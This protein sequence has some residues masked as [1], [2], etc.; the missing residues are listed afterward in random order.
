MAENAYDAVHTVPT[1]LEA[2]RVHEVGSGPPAVLW[3]SLF[4]D[5]TTWVR[6]RDDLARDRRLF[7]IDGPCHGAG[8]P[9][10]QLF[11]LRDCADAAG[12]V[13]DRL[14]VSE[15]VDWLGNAWGGHVGI[16]FAAS[17]PERC[18]SLVTIGTPVHALSA[19]DRRRT[20]PVVV[21]YRLLGPVRPLSKGLAGALLGRGADPMDVRLVTDAFRRPDRRG[22]YTAMRSVMLRR[23]DLTPTLT[24]VAAPSLFVAG[25]EDALWLPTQARAAAERLPYGASVTVPGA[26]HIAPLLQ[27]AP[28]VAGI[29]TD[30]WRDP[31]GAVV[32]RA[33]PASASKPLTAT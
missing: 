24:D 9:T 21:L 22:M 26:G 8:E 12:E 17:Q 1:R 7:L 19:A 25:A 6:V 10:R 13:L 18:R 33:A 14:E 5:S 11:T 15:P 28:T 2:L 20:V 29:V 27:A 4:V 30:F 31:A 32:R 23:P 16:V 3:H